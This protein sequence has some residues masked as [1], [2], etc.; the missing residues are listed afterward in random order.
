[1][2]TYV[3]LNTYLIGSA[4]IDSAGDNIL[5]HLELVWNNN[6]PT[7]AHGT[8]NI[9]AGESFDIGVALADNTMPSAL[10]FG[11]NGQDLT[12][13]GAGT[14]ILDN[15]NTYTGHTDV[16]NGSLIVGSTTA[17]SNAQIAG[18]VDVQNGAILGGHG[19]INGTAAINSGGTL[20]PG[21]SIGMLTLSD[22]IFNSGAT[23]QVEANPDG[24]ADRLVADSSLGGTGTVTINTGA[25][26]DIVAGT[27]IW[28]PTTSY[29]I[30]DTDG[31]VTGQFDTVTSNLAFLT[32]TVNYTIPNQVWLTLTRNNTGFG[33]LEGT[34]NENN[35][36]KGIESLGPGNEIYNTIIGMSRDQA[37]Y[38]YNN[39]SGEIHGSV[40]GAILTN[41]YARDAVNQHLS[42]GSSLRASL[43]EARKAL[44]ISAWGH[45]GH[46]KNDG[47][48]AK[49]DLQGWGFLIG[50]DVYNDGTTA[51][52]VAFGYEQTD[53]K[54]RSNRNSDADTDAIHL[55]A[56]GRTNL[57]PIDLKGGIGYSWLD[58]GT[59]R[60]V[61][62]GAIQSQN[63]ADYDGGLIQAYIEG[64]Y[65]FKLNEQT[66]MTPYVNLAYQRV[67]TDSF[68][69]KGAQAQLHNSSSS[70]HL[71]T[72]TA[73]VRGLWE[74]NSKASLYGEL[75]W[76]YNMGDIAPH[77]DLNFAGGS[78][79]TVKGTEVDRNSAII[80]LG[81]NYQ[82][83]PNI[84]LSAGYEG[85]FGNQ[86]RD[87]ALKLRFE[88]RF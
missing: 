33:D 64:S 86:S 25:A 84:R 16:Q 80:G 73:G 62:V 24:T 53:I 58:I 21:N 20:A 79:Y 4:W 75:G 48:A 49:L 72:T 14:L 50:A 74:V 82:I 59:T 69:E 70:D 85:Q 88:Y 51:G 52:G 46:L 36:G 56:Y 37:L 55:L 26:L 65:T 23:F 60:H 1:M 8:F 6:D 77:A 54:T 71:V 45:D 61:N 41:R 10:G 67:K 63:Q 22:A 17:H 31:G 11:W 76:Q 29:L 44:W 47:N 9:P 39:L 28:N 19:R 66:S 87:H 32:E 40:K 34:Y 5:A 83:K 3:D 42:N 27:G 7:S 81:G 12:K 38:A 35:T 78:T 13:T 18:N 2:H 68:T 43:L 57:G 30:I 15:V